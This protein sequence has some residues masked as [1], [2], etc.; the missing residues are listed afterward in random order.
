YLTGAWGNLGISYDGLELLPELF[1]SGRWLRL[2]REASA[3]VEERRRRWR[4]VLAITFGPWCPRGIWLGINKISGK[5]CDI[6]DYTGINP[7]HL[8][9][10]GFIA[11]AKACNH[12]LTL[13][14][15]KD[16]VALRLHL[17]KGGDP[18]NSA[19]ASLALTQV[20]MRHPLADVRLLE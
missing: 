20:D 13:R 17:L 16:G 5:L 19:K 8:N 10:S 4:G 15:V 2:W 1:R 18:G 7:R 11:R 9:D 12:D 14:P 3:L 6:G